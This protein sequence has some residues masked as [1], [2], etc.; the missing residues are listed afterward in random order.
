MVEPQ[1]LSPPPAG[2][3]GPELTAR[4]PLT[5]VSGE[6]PGI[7]SRWIIAPSKDGWTDFVL[8]EWELEAA[9]WVDHH[10]HDE[11]NLVVEGELHVETDGRAVVARPGD[12]VRVRAGSTGTYWAPRYARMIGIYGPNPDGV[13]SDYVKYW[14]IQEPGVTAR[15]G[16]V[17]NEERNTF[18]E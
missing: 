14:D 2:S 4:A 17:E 15:P 7:R 18:G 6:W 5:R 16:A 10:P 1:R 11:V 13:D 3:P 8:S 9:G 12:T